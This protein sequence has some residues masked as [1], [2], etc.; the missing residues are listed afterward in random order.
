MMIS[1]SK[2][3]GHPLTWISRRGGR[4]FDLTA[5]DNSVIPVNSVIAQFPWQATGHYVGFGGRRWD[6]A[7]ALIPDGTGLLYLNEEDG[8]I[9][10]YR[11]E[12]PTGEQ[13]LRLATYQEH[14]LKESWLEFPDERRFTWDR[15]GEKGRGSW[16]DKTSTTTYVVIHDGYR[17]RRVDIQPPAA[18]MRDSEL[19]LLLVL[20]IYNMDT[21]NYKNFQEGTLVNDAAGIYEDIRRF[22]YWLRNKRH[23]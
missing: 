15:W 3:V 17:E 21:E 10:I 19:S 9:V 6:K 2:F 8:N 13:G 1:M 7:K 14:P 16:V 20:G 11:G 4:Y 12:Q 23:G 18:E 5:S 22:R